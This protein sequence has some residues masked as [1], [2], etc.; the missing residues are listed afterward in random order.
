MLVIVGLCV[1]ALVYYGAIKPNDAAS[2]DKLVGTPI[3]LTDVL[4]NKFYAHH[5][6]ATWISDTEL[7][8]KDHMVSF[9]IRE[10]KNN[11]K[12]FF[13]QFFFSSNLF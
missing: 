11:K 6:N 4:N 2:T 7:L 3:S 10:N 13:Q 5:G 1:T 8:Y 12:T 9:K